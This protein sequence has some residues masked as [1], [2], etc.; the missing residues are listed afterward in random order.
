MSPLCHWP[1]PWD[2]CGTTGSWGVVAGTGW[3]GGLL[4]KYKHVVLKQTKND[5]KTLFFSWTL[6]Q[7]SANCLTKIKAFDTKTAM[8]YIFGFLDSL[9]MEA[10]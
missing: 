10:C 5:Q 4:F 9:E 2:H 7:F 1:C 8:N 3:A 6:T